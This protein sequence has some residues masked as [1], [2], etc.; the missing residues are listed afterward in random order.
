[1]PQT[2][3]FF[4][5]SWKLKVAEVFFP[6]PIP[7]YPLNLFDT[8]ALNEEQEEALR[9]IDTFIQQPKSGIFIL[10]GSAG[11]GKTT[12]LRQVIDRIESRHLQVQA[13][14][15]TGRAASVA[16]SKTGKNFKTVHRSI[17]KEPVPKENEDAQ[18]YL[19]CQR[20][21][22]HSAITSVCLIDEAGM[23]SDVDQRGELLRF[24]S[25][26]LLHDLYHYLNLA[27]TRRKLI[28]SGDPAQLPPIHCDR[29]PALDPRFWKEHYQIVPQHYH[30]TQI[31]R[32]GQQTALSEYVQNLRIA[33][34]NTD[35][36]P[37]PPP[38][39]ATDVFTQKPLEALQD[40]LEEQ[41]P[42]NRENKIVIAWTN[43]QCND[44]NHSIRERTY[45]DHETLHYGEIVLNTINRFVDDQAIMNGD[46]LIIENPELKKPETKTIAFKSTG[47]IV[48]QITLTFLFLRVHWP[49]EPSKGLEVCSIKETLF[50][51]QELQRNK[52]T[53]ALYVD[54]K[55]R[56]T[57]LK[58][59]TA[60]FATAL[61]TDPYFNCLMLNFGYAVT[62]HK[63]QGGEWDKVYADL[64]RLPIDLSYR[65][66]WVYTAA[67]RSSRALSLLHEQNPNKEKPIEIAPVEPLK[68][69]SAQRYHFPEIWQELELPAHCP[70]E[71]ARNPYFYAREKLL[72]PN[73]TLRFE[74]LQFKIRIQVQESNQIATLDFDYAKS[75][76]KEA[77]ILNGSTELARTALNA[78]KEPPSE[79]FEP[80]LNHPRLKALWTWLTPL[81]EE[82]HWII[83]NREEA[84][85]LDRLHIFGL[86]DKN[87][88]ILEFSYNKEDRYTRLV[89]KTQ[90]QS[91]PSLLILLERIKESF[92][93]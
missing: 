61:K 46:F 45:A 2:S 81:L 75:G 82:Y 41:E 87:W 93:T 70:D 51:E 5:H 7:T 25:G 34:E 84:Q 91:D 58:V 60:E 37:A 73:R 43:Q 22:D 55:N 35:Q 16:R 68:N 88:R 69:L 20:R 4:F 67:T 18:L 66:R 85:Y 33:V 15:Y 24:G 44:W 13:M 48:Q 11:T 92:L 32:Q 80:D 42:A 83:T 54:F 71:L 53:Q 21:E 23:L 36:K 31:H 1:M 79:V 40:Y 47:G 9:Q 76:P 77:K 49:H 6:Y 63:A 86:S 14:A 64:T 27:Q 38:P 8:I 29:S 39:N 62:A 72:L 65:R 28:L 74:F 10:T 26:R 19:S 78:L 59:G 30:L 57:D 90:I 3:A 12:V 52:L 89:A 56:H 17:Y 50:P